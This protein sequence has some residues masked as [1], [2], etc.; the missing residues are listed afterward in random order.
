MEVTLARSEDLEEIA[1]LFDRYQIV[2]RQL[3]DIE[4]DRKFLQQRF[5]RGDARIFVARSLYSS[6]GYIENEEFYQ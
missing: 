2:D 4:T 6:L 3:S 5:D 1:K